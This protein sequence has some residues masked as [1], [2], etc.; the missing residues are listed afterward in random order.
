VEKE[1]LPVIRTGRV[2]TVA[3]I[4]WA[5]FEAALANGEHVEEINVLEVILARKGPYGP[6][7]DMI[8]SLG[9]MIHP[10]ES[11]EQGLMREVAEESTLLTF[12]SRQTVAEWEQSDFSSR[13]P[14]FRYEINSARAPRE[15]VIR[16]LPV[17]SSDFSRHELRKHPDDNMEELIHVS[18][19]V[20]EEIIRTGKYVHDGKTDR[21]VGHLTFPAAD[22]TLCESD[23]EKQQHTLQSVIETVY[24]V[25]KSWKL[26]LLKTISF[27]RAIRNMPLPSSLTECT[28]HE[29]RI[30]WIAMQMKMDFSE[31]RN[32]EKVHSYPISR[33][34][35]Y[36]K[37]IQYLS[38]VPPDLTDELFSFLPT[39]QVI[40]RVND[41]KWAL[42]HT[43]N[44]VIPQEYIQPNH[45]HLNIS[46]TLFDFWK[47]LH[48]MPLSERVGFLKDANGRY[49][50]YLS[51]ELGVSEETLE[52]AYTVA[53][54]IPH[55]INDSLAVLGSSFQEYRTINEVTNAL[56]F[57]AT[58]MALGFN[59]N[60]PE[61]MN[62][63]YPA[64]T[65]LEF[66]AMRTIANFM[67][68][69]DAIQKHKNSENL[70][71]ETA[72]ENYFQWPPIQEII[73]FGNGVVHPVYHR[74]TRDLIDGHMLHVI[75]D[76]RIKKTPESIVRKL[77]QEPL[78]EIGDIFAIN[79]AISDDSY[80][81][82]ASC[83]DRLRVAELL[84]S[85]FISYLRNMYEPDGW[86]IDVQDD[87]GIP[88]GQIRTYLSLDTPR[89]RHEY[90]QTLQKGKRAGSR[91]KL[92]IRDQFRIMFEKDGIENVC[93]INIYP[94]ESITSPQLPPMV[95]ESGL[96]GF[97]EKLKDTAEGH[98]DA[99]RI[100]M[101][102]STW[103]LEP[104]LHELLYPS[105]YYDWLIVRLAGK[106]IT[107]RPKDLLPNM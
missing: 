106:E 76:E 21:M 71:I 90:V 73:D 15:T 72:I 47:E 50:R 32:R 4:P 62:D 6:S 70:L 26:Q 52:Q 54:A 65:T 49:L 35:D 95:R 10:D 60:L 39:R 43:L 3:P 7:A 100:L 83:E 75:V 1:R 96:W 41:V 69:I 97:T 19:H 53:Q 88:F 81:E 33:H 80:P 55:Y 36:V 23:H 29:L 40:E 99:R 79:L 25:Q 24:D 105:Q 20:F 64:E 61:R 93:E 82:G 92:I 22:I 37:A 78:E 91:G 57:T 103:P 11:D 28:H 66:E 107:K 27:G 58:L 104:S 56:P 94:F 98:Y 86:N 67:T 30:G 45:F 101:R 51:H 8:T 42:I 46:G 87:Y 77:Y 5:K 48:R 17:I 34:A 74:Q 102:N 14:T 12:H 89:E 59:P 85:S 31:E 9:G 13:Y 18:P 16:V 68:A 84:K 44:D 2:I 38:S 63:Q